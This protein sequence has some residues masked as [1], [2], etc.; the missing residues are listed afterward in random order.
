VRIDAFDVQQFTADGKGNHVQRGLLLKQPC[1]LHEGDGVQIRARL[2]RPAYCYWLAY[3]PD[4]VEE[5]CF[6]ES[7]SEPPPLTDQPAYPWKK[8]DRLDTMFGFTEGPGWQAFLLIVSEKPLPAYSEWKKSRGAAPWRPVRS[9]AGGV[10]VR[11]DGRWLESFHPAGRNAT[12]GKGDRLN[13]GDAGLSEL[14][15]WA[16]GDENVVALEAW[17][18]PVLPRRGAESGS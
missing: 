2:S 18:I 6:P 1:I 12:R 9:A 3:R 5:L 10:I 14:I 15:R 11:H 13:V 7:E 4:G 16:E 17:A 8:S